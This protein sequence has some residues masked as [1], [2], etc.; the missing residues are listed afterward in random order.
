MRCGLGGESLRRRLGGRSP[1]DG[2]KGVDDAAV[3]L[4]P[5]AGAR[6][7]PGGDFEDGTAGWSLSGG[8]AVA[9]GNA[10]QSV[11]G[12]D[13]ASSLAI[14]SGASATSASICVG[15]GHPTMRFFAKRRATGPLGG[16]STLR[17][18]RRSLLAQV[19]PTS[20]RRAGVRP[21]R[22]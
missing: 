1:Q 21:D 11:R 5:G 10:T 16:L 13:D 18:V 12:D 20:S 2:D 22:Q 3:E 6:L 4:R 8:A 7:L 19:D 9:S 15:L 14:A 17:V